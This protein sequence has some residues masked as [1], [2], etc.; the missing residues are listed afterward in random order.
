MFDDLYCTTGGLK[1][2]LIRIQIEEKVKLLHMRN[3]TFFHNVFQSCLKV[4]EISIDQVK[5]Y[6]ILKTYEQ[7]KW[8]IVFLIVFL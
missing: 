4:V 1:Y 3:F 5:G 6:F 7:S 8:Q 2:R